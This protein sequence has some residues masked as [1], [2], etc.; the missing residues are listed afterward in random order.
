MERALGVVGIYFAVND[1]KYSLQRGDGL[2]AKSMDSLAPSSLVVQGLGFGSLVGLGGFG[3]TILVQ[4]RGLDDV[5]RGGFTSNG[6]KR[7]MVG[8][9]CPNDGHG[10]VGFARIGPWFGYPQV[11]VV[12]GRA[13]GEPTTMG[14]KAQKKFP[15]FVLRNTGIVVVSCPVD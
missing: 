7:G 3:R 12:Y 6:S 11:D 1:Q 5:R 8:T 13:G 4:S 10:P 14:V 15:Y 9:T 2:V